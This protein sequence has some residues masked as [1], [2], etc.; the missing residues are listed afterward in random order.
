MASDLDGAPV[1]MAT[2]AERT[3]TPALEAKPENQGGQAARFW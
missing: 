3:R 1:F 2:T